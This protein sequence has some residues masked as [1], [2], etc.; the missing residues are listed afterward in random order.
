MFSSVPQRMFSSVPQRMFSSVPQRMF[1]SVPQR[2]FSSVPQRMFS[3]VPQRMFSSVPQRMFSSVPQRM[4]SSVPQR[5]FS[6][7]Q[8]SLDANTT[9]PDP[10]VLPATTV[11]RTA[12]RTCS[13]RAAARFRLPA[14]PPSSPSS[15][16]GS[17]ENCT[18]MRTA[19]GVSCR[20]LPSI[21]L[22]TAP[23]TTGV[24]M[25]VPD[26][27]IRASRPTPVMSSGRAFASVE[28]GATSPRI[29]LPGATTS[30]LIS[31][32]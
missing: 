25:L 19:P 26:S 16:S 4:F 21:R 8:R 6:A 31:R 2:M 22:A 10:T 20:R 1:S 9:W 7:V 12:P 15:N 29:R 14:P 32:S 18:R 23:D 5:M 13:S 28:F 17:A 27:S 3:L 30:G 24:A 11:S